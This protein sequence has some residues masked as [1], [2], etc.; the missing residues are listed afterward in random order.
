MGRISRKCYES[1]YFHVMVK[2]IGNEFIFKTEKNKEKY[3][4]SLIISTKLTNSKILAYCIMDNHAHIL[5]YVDNVSN[6]TKIMSST[7]TKFAIYYNKTLKRNGFVFRDRYRCENIY[8]RSY[9]ENCIRYIHRNPV[10]ANLCLKESDYKFSTYGQYENKSG[11]INDEIIKLAFESIENYMEKLNA[12]I[13]YEKFIDIDNEFGKEDYEMLDDVIDSVT[14]N[15]NIDL[16]S[17]SNEDIVMLGNEL[18]KRCNVT[19]KEIA[20]KLKVERTK[21]IRLMKGK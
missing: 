16:E 12:K 7:N 1:N 21:F 15:E 18:I 20:E 5:L 10:E 13:G 9:L 6:L 17:L 3:I 2:G 19:K 11:I 8:T 14:K 4:D